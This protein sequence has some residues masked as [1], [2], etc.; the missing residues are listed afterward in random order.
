MSR[1]LLLSLL[2]MTSALSAQ[3]VKSVIPRTTSGKP[4]LT[5]VWQPGST[6]PGNWEDANSGLGVGGTGRN[7]S[8]PAAPSSNDRPANREAAPYQ[9]WAAQKVLEAYNRRSIDDPSALCLPIGLPR[10]DLLGLFPV[11]IIQTPSQI[12]ILYEYMSV[13]R[14]IP[15]NAKHPEDVL[16]SYTGN[17]VA[18]WEG[19]TLVVDVTG[20]NDKTWLAGAGTFHSDA[21][22]IVERFTRNEKDRINFDVTIEDPKV[23]TKPWTIHSSWM[24]RTGTRLEEYVCAENNLDPGQ[25]EKLLKE[26]IKFNRE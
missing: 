14:V 7:P 20:F 24:L 13:F 1:F 21:L 15:L 23:L 3:T 8:A 11:Q 9:P 19:D 2:A 25:Y 6:Q 12:A 10:A 5:G 4:D 18:H 17:S 16:P 22:H 26:G